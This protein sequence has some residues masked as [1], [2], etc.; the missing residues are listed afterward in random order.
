MSE[1][2]DVH[3]ED[4]TATERAVNAARLVLSRALDA[5]E[6]A[7]DAWRD[8]SDARKAASNEV[9]RLARGATDG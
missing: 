6:A 8:A 3:G 1:S 9:D 4:V 7:Y 5:E 2:S